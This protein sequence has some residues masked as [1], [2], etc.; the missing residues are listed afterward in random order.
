MDLEKIEKGTKVKY[1]IF[2]NITFE[3]T[4]EVHVILKDKNGNVKKVY[5]SLFLKYGRVEG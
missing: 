1:D 4:D 3:G 2:Q 5:K